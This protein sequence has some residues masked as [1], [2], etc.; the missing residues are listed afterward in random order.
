[1][2][3][4]SKIVVGDIVILKPGSEIVADG[5]TVEGQD[6]VIDESAISGINL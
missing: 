1:M 2:I 5:V 6:I 4:V 3:H